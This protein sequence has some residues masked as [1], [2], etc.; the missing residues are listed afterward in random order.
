LDCPLR[1]GAQTKTEVAE[2]RVNGPRALSIAVRNWSADEPEYLTE[3]VRFLRHRK[4]YQNPER[5]NAEQYQIVGP[6]PGIFISPDT[7]SP[8]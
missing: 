6:H 2:L 4:G 7:Q 3:G 1:G 5:A 8:V